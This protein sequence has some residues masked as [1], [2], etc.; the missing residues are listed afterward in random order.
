M[1]DTRRLHV[2]N[3]PHINVL[4]FCYSVRQEED[5]HHDRGGGGKH[6]RGCTSVTVYSRYTHTLTDTLI[7]RSVTANTHTHTRCCLLVRRGA[8]QLGLYDLIA[9]VLL[10][11][12][13]PAVPSPRR[14]RIFSQEVGTCC[15]FLADCSLRAWGLGGGLG[16]PD[17]RRSEVTFPC[18]MVAVKR[19]PC[20]LCCV[21]ELLMDLGNGDGGKWREEGRGGSGEFQQHSDQIAFL[22]LF[23]F[24]S[25]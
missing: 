23:L 1:S 7:S 8:E 6:L 24:F 2:I 16:G 22:S 10:T 17:A 19:S 14:G 9:P 5:R 11:P 12:P 4:F 15:S 3:P 13:H 18:I 20:P 25:A 21:L